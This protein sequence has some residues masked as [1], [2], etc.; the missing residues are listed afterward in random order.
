RPIYLDISFLPKQGRKIFLLA[1]WRES[2]GKAGVFIHIKYL[3]M[4]SISICLNHLYLLD[5]NQNSILPVSFLGTKTLE[6]WEN[7]SF[8]IISIFL[9]ENKPFMLEYFARLQDEAISWIQAGA[10]HVI[11]IILHSFLFVFQFTF[12]LGMIWI[13]P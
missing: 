2:H 7:N 4:V 5:T 9:R 1:P 12:E 6:I 8:W 3:Q 13:T 10:I 11:F